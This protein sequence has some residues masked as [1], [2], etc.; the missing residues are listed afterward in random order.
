MEM[1]LSFLALEDGNGLQSSFLLATGGHDNIVRLWDFQIS[2]EISLAKK[3]ELTGHQ[4]TVYSVKFSP[5]GSVLAS[6][7]GDKS[8]RIWN[9]VL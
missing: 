3:S 8:V 9:S 4:E 7:G 2:L 6:A 5:D 1:R